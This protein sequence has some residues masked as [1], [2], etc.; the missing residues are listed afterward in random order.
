MRYLAVVS[1]L[2]L[3]L[4]WPARADDHLEGVARAGM[5]VGTKIENFDAVARAFKIPQRAGS[6]RPRRWGSNRK[7]AA[8]LR[9]WMCA[10]FPEAASS[11]S[12]SP[13]AATR[14]ERSTT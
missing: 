10:A 14:R 12:S 6:G 5:V 7:A 4:V 1:V 13:R 8:N 2:F 9:H 11:I 3:G